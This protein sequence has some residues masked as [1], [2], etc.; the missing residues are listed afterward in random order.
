MRI[1]KLTGE[2]GI[3]AAWRGSRAGVCW[4][5]VLSAR[6]LLVSGFCFSERPCRA[7]SCNPQLWG[8]RT[9]RLSPVPLGRLSPAS[10]RQR[11]EWRE[12]NPRL[13]PSPRSKR[14]CFRAQVVWGWPR[15]PVPQASLCVLSPANMFL[16]H[17]RPWQYAQPSPHTSVP[18]LHHLPEIRHFLGF[19]R[20]IPL[21]PAL[22]LS[23]V[24]SCCERGE[25]RPKDLTSLPGRPVAESPSFVIRLL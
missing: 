4:P 18:A 24:P 14:G 22:T 19:Q 25:G 7:V 12:A 8:H 20:D 1:W 17:E 15:P 6:W 16:L 3:Q 21:L 2:R 10:H 5:L 9:L 23:S 11:A 13:L